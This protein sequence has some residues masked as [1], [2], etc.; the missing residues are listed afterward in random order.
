MG[1][2]EFYSS[3]CFCSGAIRVPCKF[4]IEAEQKIGIHLIRDYGASSLALKH[5]CLAGQSACRLRQT[6]WG[7][8]LPVPVVIPDARSDFPTAGFK[9]SRMRFGEPP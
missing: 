8:W 4:A 6:P 1:R 2:N 3:L 9:P 5:L 7:V